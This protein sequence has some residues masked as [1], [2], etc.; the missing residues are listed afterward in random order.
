MTLD[1]ASDAIVQRY[2][3]RVSELSQ[4]QH[5]TPS[6]ADLEA[7]ALEVGISPEVLQQARQVSQDHFHRGVEWVQQQRWA[8]AI[9]ELN[10]SLELNP[11]SPETH[12]QLA[13]AHRGKFEMTGEEGDRQTALKHVQQCLHLQPNFRS[14]LDLQQSLTQAASSSASKSTPWGVVAGVLASGLMGLAAVVTLILRPGSAPTPNPVASAPE[15]TTTPTPS[16]TDASSNATTSATASEVDIPLE[17]TDS[18]TTAGISV[19]P[20]LSRL[21]NYAES[22]FYEM[23]A[24][25]V[26]DSDQEW[27]KVSLTAEWLDAQGNVLMQKPLRALDTFQSPMRPGDRHPFATITEISPGLQ[28]IRLS[29]QTADTTPAASSYDPG[30]VVPVTWDTQQASHW[31][32]EV[33]ERQ[34]SVRPKSFEEGDHAD[35]IFAIT[36][37]GSAAFQKLRLEIRFL[38][39]NGTVLGTDDMQVVYGSDPPLLVGETR[40]DRTVEGIQSGYERYEIVVVEAE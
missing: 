19:E 22:S 34:V 18:L 13:L 11:S 9:A 23:Q 16:P 27:Q 36:N 4:T 25:L 1:P 33:R 30:T 37:T 17:L 32:L 10:N 31:Q 35:A 26:N 39:A 28:T 3:K 14:A 2:V 15:P 7:I 21:S 12:Y 20:R 5:K 40:L 29:L 24:L 38:D 8:E 6:Q